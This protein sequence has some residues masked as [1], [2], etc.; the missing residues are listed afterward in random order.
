MNTKF[1]PQFPSGESD[2]PYVFICKN[3]RELIVKFPL[4]GKH[5]I[6]KSKTWVAF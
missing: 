2:S 6:C 5:K 3:P 1:V 4:K